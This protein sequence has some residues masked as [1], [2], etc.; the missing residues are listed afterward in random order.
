MT[1]ATQRESVTIRDVVYPGRGLS[2][3]ADGRIV[4]I[5]EALAGERVAI[6]IVKQHAQ[7]AIGRVVDILMPSPHRIATC[8]GEGPR[9]G[10]P[11]CVYQHIAYPYEV[12]IKH[13]QLHEILRRLG[14]LEDDIRLPPTASPNELHYRNKIVLHAAP[15]EGG[16]KLGYIRDDNT[17]VHDIEACMLAMDPI[18]ATLAEI[19]ADAA[20]MDSLKPGMSVTLRHTREEGTVFW[21]A[22]ETVEPSRLTEETPFGPVVVPRRS[23]YQVNPA[24]ANLL[25]TATGEAVARLAPEFVIDLYCGCGVFSLAALHAGTRAVYGIDSDSRAIRAARLNVMQHRY[26][27][28][29]FFTAQSAYEGL[30]GIPARVTPESTLVM[31]DP[32]RGGLDRD[33]VQLLCAVKPGHILYISCAPDTLARDMAR[34]M[35]SGYRPRSARLFDLFPRTA[36]FE[37]LMHLEYAG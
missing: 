17:T 31:V 20:F 13:R 4:F 21:R 1:D 2:S 27:S 24:A 18:N 19:R 22:N 37:T 29:A 32:P 23:F 25:F 33:L 3:L 11:G 8:C 9:A 34:F 28:Q 12:E 14:R 6:E 5:P 36:H 35:E 26:Q 30:Q 15:S 7:Y 16:V 10:C